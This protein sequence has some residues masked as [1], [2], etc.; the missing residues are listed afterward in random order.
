MWGGLETNDRGE[1]RESERAISGSRISIQKVATR[2]NNYEGEG[3]AL[4][5]AEK[6]TLSLDEFRAILGMALELALEADQLRY[7]RIICI[8]LVS[9]RRSASILRAYS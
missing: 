4:R 2:S 8:I 7:A 6:V 5:N 3:A 9:D 1:V